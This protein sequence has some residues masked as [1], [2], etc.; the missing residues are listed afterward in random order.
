[1]TGG[2]NGSRTRLMK[3]IPVEG[4]DSRKQ[5]KQYFTPRPAAEFMVANSSIDGK[6]KIID[7][8]VGNGVFIDAV[9]NREF[10]SFFG[11]DVDGQVIS[12]LKQE[13]SGNSRVK[14]FQGNALD[15]DCLSG[16]LRENYYDLAIGNPPFSNQKNRIKDR[17]ILSGYQL[18]CKSQS[19]ETLFL[20]R[21][22]NLL[23]PGGQL[24]IILPIN[25]FANTNLEYVRDYILRNVD[26]EAVVQLPPGV[27]SNTSARTAILFGV[28]KEDDKKQD[29]R[30]KLIQVDDLESLSGLSIYDKSV[31]ITKE[32]GD[33]VC[34]MDPGYH[35]G[36]KKLEGLI[37]GSSLN[38]VPL[39]K[40]A[41]I[42]NGYARYGEYR[43]YIYQNVV[44]KDQDRY[45]RLI[46]AKNVTPLG[47]RL[48]DNKFY[49]RKDGPIYKKTAVVKKGDI[50]FVRVGVGCIGRA[51]YIGKKDPGA[52][53]DDWFFIIRSKKV[54]PYFLAFYLNSNPG[55]EF[56]NVEKQG[57]GTVSISKRRLKNVLIPILPD[58]VQEEF[59]DEVI[60]IYRFYRRNEYKKAER[61][62]K[63]LD[64][65]L[66]KLTGKEIGGDE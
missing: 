7:P 1:M 48:D 58:S 26:T 2:W 4:S 9:S 14:L 21:F 53:V 64:Y 32:P 23:R 62:F 10:H 31:G 35:L 49:I 51:V 18:G 30:I 55:R 36:K 60:N 63:N 17:A 44:K 3:N 33:L 52:Q 47:L 66:K 5:L 43:E 56:I 38:F 24:R 15:I 28:K 50:I 37:R 45:V 25:I 41:E 59:A 6:S 57:T 13:N 34:R 39:G 11:I 16:V 46:K 65:R 8:S 54:N 61:I 12:K 27:F 40:T 19:L 42:R 29:S 22:I 20:E